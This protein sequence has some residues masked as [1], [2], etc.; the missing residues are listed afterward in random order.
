MWQQNY[1]NIGVVL[2]ADLQGAEHLLRAVALA[3]DVQAQQDA[4]RAVDRERYA[5]WFA[6]EYGYKPTQV[7]RAAR[8]GYAAS[9]RRHSKQSYHAEKIG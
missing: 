9:L 3:E 4:G 1:R 6:I 7:A 8:L 2:Q 5:E